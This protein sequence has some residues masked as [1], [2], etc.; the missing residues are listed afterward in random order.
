[1]KH[2]LKREEVIIPEGVEV[3][4][5]CRI[6]TIKGPRGLIEKNFR[7]A[8]VDIRIETIKGVKKLVI[9]MWFGTSRNA[10][11]VTTIA[12]RIKNAII[13]VTKG[14]LFTMD[15]LRIHFPIVA[16]ISNKGKT[17]ELKNFLG[18]RDVYKIK[19][20]P[21]C[22]LSMKSYDKCESSH[23]KWPLE[24]SGIDLENVSM[25]CA[26]IHR[27]L[28]EN[29]RKDDRK[30]LDGLYIIKRTTIGKT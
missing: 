16:T 2:L 21:G 17:L 9:D 15:E 22:T 4:A 10:S 30:F 13:G 3:T 26:M 19:V 5:K 7:H 12:T 8:A 27:A 25:T 18:G 28:K 11:V 14:Y 23:N 1:M 6:V 29:N 24:I 20:L